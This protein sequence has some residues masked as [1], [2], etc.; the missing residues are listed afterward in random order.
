MIEYVYQ[1]IING[2]IKPSGIYNT[3]NTAK[4]DLESDISFYE[5]MCK[6]FN[7]K[8]EFIKEIP[9]S[10]TDTLGIYMKEYKFIHNAITEHIVFEIDPVQRK[11]DYVDK[12]EFVKPEYYIVTCDRRETGT[13]YANA[14]G[15][16]D[17]GIKFESIRSAKEYIYSKTIEIDQ[18]FKK[19]KPKFK[20]TKY[21]SVDNTYH[22][23]M[24]YMNYDEG[25][26]I[27]YDFDIIPKSIK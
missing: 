8:F 14:T 2:I 15:P 4:F 17:S 21:D 12:E 9:K 22:F 20:K 24:A 5:S 19:N 1:K 11:E 10:F 25:T 16:I 7:F 23:L 3:Y 27:Y 26:D 13:N 6:D 18:D